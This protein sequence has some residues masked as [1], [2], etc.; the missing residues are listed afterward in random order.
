MEL[1]ETDRTAGRIDWPA[2]GERTPASDRARTSR[3]S[4]TLARALSGIETELEDRLDAT[5]IRLSTAA[6]QR[7]TDG[8]P[9]ADARPDD[10]GIVVRWT[11]DGRDYA[12]ACDRY[13]SL[14]DNAR[15]VGLWIKETRK[16]GDRPVEHGADAF[17]AAALPGGA[18]DSPDVVVADDGSPD[19]EQ[20][21][22]RL[23]VSPDAP[24]AAVRGAFR[25]LAKAGHA[26]HGGDADVGALQQARDVLLDDE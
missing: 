16:R 6:P 22:A 21:A 19:R 17:A 3:F 12:V 15:E 26:D 13:Q 5:A 18:G 10:P 14:R 25:E 24:E 20:A 2:W 1:N 4:V 9:Y 11:V 8:H 7:Q 23:G